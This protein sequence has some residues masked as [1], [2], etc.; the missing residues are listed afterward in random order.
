MTRRAF[1]L[2]EMALAVLLAGFVIL[3][4][5]GMFAMVD[6][7]ERS[8]TARTADIQVMAQCHATLRRAIQSLV[9]KPSSGGPA[10]R[11]D[12][13]SPATTDLARE[14][15]GDRPLAEQLG[16]K[17]PA[18]PA[19]PTYHMRLGAFDPEHPEKPPKSAGK[20]RDELKPARLDVVLT[21]S[22]FNFTPVTEGPIRGAFDVVPE[23]RED[24]QLVWTPI[25]P[26]GEEIV[27]ADNLAA[28]FMSVLE[29]E[30]GWVDAFE[31]RLVDDFPRA[32]RVVIWTRGGATADWLFEPGVTT[33]DAPGD[34]SADLPATEGGEGANPDQGV[35]IDGGSG[36]PTTDTGS[37]VAP[38]QNKA[39]KG[40]QRHRPMAPGGQP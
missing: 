35:P 2:I 11:T 12:E 3:T 37:A 27:L 14:R 40:S 36:Q 23:G 8:L 26:P 29:R 13:G 32:V 19:R 34:S 39:K 22:P 7:A 28:V 10:R 18:T 21:G 38:T 9:A 1:T 5:L 4:S 30:G 6:R 17:T 31:A 24:W 15:F 20:N 25:D 33:G 16:L